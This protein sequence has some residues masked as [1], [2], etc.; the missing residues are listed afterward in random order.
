MSS[1]VLF[2]EGKEHIALFVMYIFDRNWLL[3]CTLSWV[4]LTTRHMSPWQIILLR[5]MLPYL[6][7]TCI[8]INKRLRIYAL[9]HFRLVF[10][11][12]KSQ[13]GKVREMRFVLYKLSCWQR[14]WI[15][16]YLHI[17]SI[18]SCSVPFNSITYL[19]SFMK[20]G[21]RDILVSVGA[22]LRKYRSLNWAS[23]P[24]RGKIF[25]STHVFQVLCSSLYSCAS[26]CCS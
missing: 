6:M 13:C 22:E 14:L 9:Y 23:I 20:F 18:S 24:G 11:S 12:T 10:L 8:S 7:L 19:L 16:K 5:N 4:R 2:T 1:T 17:L 25:F 26:N 3:L 21:S 15:D